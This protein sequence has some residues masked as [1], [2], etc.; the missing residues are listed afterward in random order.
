MIKIGNFGNT[1]GWSHAIIMTVKPPQYIIYIFF[2]IP[3]VKIPSPK[4]AADRWLFF[5]YLK[6]VQVQA[7]I[8]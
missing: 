8:V 1:F 6:Y 4:R 2:T 5:F 3:I 7:I